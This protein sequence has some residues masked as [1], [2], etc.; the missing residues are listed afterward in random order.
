MIILDPTQQ[1]GNPMPP[2]PADA[3][4]TDMPTVPS[5]PV[6]PT[7]PVVPE[8]VPSTPP[9]VIPGAEEP[10]EE[11]GGTPGGTLPPTGAPTI[12]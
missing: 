11:E 6:V 3:P 8:P 12:Q 5:T 7:T 10:K 4:A 1:P 9:V 2:A